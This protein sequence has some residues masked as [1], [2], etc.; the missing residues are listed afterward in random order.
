[1]DGHRLFRFVAQYLILEQR[2]DVVGRLPEQFGP[3][4]EDVLAADALAV[5]LPADPVELRRRAG[6]DRAVGGAIAHIAVGLLVATDQAHRQPAR[7]E[8]DVESTVALYVRQAA[9]GPRGLG[10]G[11]YAE[12][13]G[14]NEGGR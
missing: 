2:R 4:A 3:A 6:G 7:H 10:G 13:R 5:A 8:W 12:R 11:N 1:M 9:V 14:G